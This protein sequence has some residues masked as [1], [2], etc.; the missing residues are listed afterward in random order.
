MAA[1]RQFKNTRR[2]RPG[3][4]AGTQQGITSKSPTQKRERST[5]MDHDAGRVRLYDAPAH[6]RESRPGCGF[7]SISAAA[8]SSAGHSRASMFHTCASAA[9]S[10][11]SQMS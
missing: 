7:R 3:Y 6:Y 2:C 11:R 1:N 4:L 8:A 9:R 10:L 5:S